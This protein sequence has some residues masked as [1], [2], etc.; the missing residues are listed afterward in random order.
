MSKHDEH[1]SVLYNA[2]HDN[3]VAVFPDDYQKKIPITNCYSE[4]IISVHTECIGI[5]I[6]SAL[7]LHMDGTKL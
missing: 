7:L 4:V 6:N 2:H 1:Y 3:F 5:I